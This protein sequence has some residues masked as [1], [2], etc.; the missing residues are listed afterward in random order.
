MNA[1]LPQSAAAADS[2]VSDDYGSTTVPGP[3]R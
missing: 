2:L 3:S 1:I